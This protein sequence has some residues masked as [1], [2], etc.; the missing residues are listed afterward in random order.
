MQ[1][2]DADPR[3]MIDLPGVGPCPRPVDIDQ[4]V[5]GFSTL[6]SLRIYAFSK[7]QVIAGES[8]EDEVYVVPLGG[9]IGLTVTG[10]CPMV[11]EMSDAGLRGL[12]MPPDHAY[13]LTAQED[14]Q[15]AYARAAAV[16][17]TAT[18]AIDGRIGDRAEVL[19]FALHDLA[20]GAV[21]PQNSTPERLVHVII[22]GLSVFGRALLAGQTLALGDGEAAEVAGRGNTSVLLVHV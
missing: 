5:T 22:G 15:V 17:N 7:G 8:E 18:H 6:K 16:G 14:V 21:L 9:A 20:D 13:R 4:R 12:Y 19:R 10:A 11:S 3:R 1:I 2:I